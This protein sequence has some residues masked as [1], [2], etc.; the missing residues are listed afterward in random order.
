M[1][2]FLLIRHGEN[3]YVRKGRLPGRMPGVHLNER[4]RAQALALA[5]KL[6]DAP[7]KT[8]Y[9]SPLERARETA[10]PIA[11]VLN[12]PV[13]L[14]EGLTETDVG[15]WQGRSLKNLRRLKVW[16][17][18]QYTP[19]QFRFPGGEGFADAQERIRGEIEALRAQHDPKDMIVCVTHA[20]PIKLAVAFYIGLP[21][22]LFQRLY[23]SPAS[24]TALMISEHG[25]GLLNLNY[26]ISLNFSKR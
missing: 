3:D 12:L 2:V 20:D 24:I 22:D 8:V 16:R 21:L 1:P 6:K 18:V 23:V 15:E 25:S 26:D 19:S 17:G 10:Q 7:V 9:S 14:R 11:D 5:E 4:G 13:I